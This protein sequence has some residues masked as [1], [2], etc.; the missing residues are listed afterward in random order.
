MS[1]GKLNKDQ[2]LFHSLVKYD[3]PYLVSTTANNKKAIEELSEDQEKA[4]TIL[5]SIF[6]R[7]K[8]TTSLNEDNED[9]SLKDA[10]NKILPPK[11]IIMNGQ[12]WVQYVSCTPVTKMEVENLKTGLE[13]RLKTLKAK[14]TGIC[15]IREDYTKNV[16]MS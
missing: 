6:Y 16:L 3:T 4:N 9:F 11:K 14:E 2:Q 7:N 5:R 15:P 8:A 13:K 12:L 1:S 10:L